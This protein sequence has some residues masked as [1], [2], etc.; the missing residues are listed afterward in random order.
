MATGDE[1]TLR[2]LHA[3]LVLVVVSLTVEHTISEKLVKTVLLS[4]PKTWN[5]ICKGCTKGFLC[6]FLRE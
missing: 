3:K 6:K 4:E 1:L 2:L 5:S